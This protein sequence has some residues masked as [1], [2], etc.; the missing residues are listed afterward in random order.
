L[1]QHKIHNKEGAEGAKEWKTVGYYN[2]IESAIRGYCKRSQRSSKIQG[3]DE[4]CL[5]EEEL[6]EEVKNLSKLINEQLLCKS[7]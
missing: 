3:W 7:E 2:N 1:I 6:I 4:F 5:L